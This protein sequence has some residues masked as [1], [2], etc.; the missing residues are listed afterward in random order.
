[1]VYS[2]ILF[3]YKYITNIIIIRRVLLF[4]KGNSQ[5]EMMSVYLEV[6]M[7]T[8]SE[9]YKK[10][11]S[12]CG[13]FSVVISNP[14]NPKHYFTNSKSLVIYNYLSFFSNLNC[15]CSSSFLWRGN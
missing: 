15:R 4:P 11:W 1:M 9:G 8:K 7:D 5:H 6:V 12:V 3:I 14:D 10:D 2:C 13:Q